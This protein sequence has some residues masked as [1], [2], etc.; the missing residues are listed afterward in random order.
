MIVVGVAIFIQG[1]MTGAVIRA[2]VRFLEAA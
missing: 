1:W 2:T